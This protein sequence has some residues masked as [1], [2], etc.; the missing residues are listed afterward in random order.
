VGGFRGGLGAYLGAAAD[1]TMGSILKD[2]GVV[3]GWL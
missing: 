3:C 1:L 2:V